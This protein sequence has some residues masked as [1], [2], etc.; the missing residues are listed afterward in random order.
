[1]KKFTSLALAV[2]SLA[3]CNK[4]KEFVPAASQA[5]EF[6]ITATRESG[7]TKT[8]L[9]ADGKSVW[10]SVGDNI[11][12]FYGPGQTPSAFIGQNTAE[13]ASAEFRGTLDRS[14]SLDEYPAEARHMFGIYP[15]GSSDKVDADGTIWLE[16]R[17]SQTAVNGSFET[18][19]FPA[20]AV[21]DNEKFNFLNVA[22][23]IRFSVDAEDVSYVKFS[24]NGNE[25]LAGRVGVKFSDGVPVVGSYDTSFS[26]VCVY[27][28]KEGFVKGESYYAVLLPVTFANGITIT[29]VPNSGDPIEIVSGKAQTLKRSTIADIGTIG[30]PKALEI[31]TVWAKFSTS[32][33]AWNEYY[34]GTAGTDRNIAMDDD[35]VYIAENSVT[36]KLWA[37]SISDHNSVT[38]VNI[39]GVSG[40]THP[41]SCPRVIKN[42]NPAVNGGKDVLACSSLTRGGE[43]PK[44]YLWLDGINNP[45]K[46]V[47]LTTWATDSWYGDTFTVSGTLQDGVLFFDKTDSGGNGIVTFNLQGVPGDKLYLLKRIAFNA[48]FGSHNGICAYY[49]FPEN[50]NCGIFSPGR[51]HE[52]RGQFA[53]FDGDLKSEVNVP[54]TP[55]LTPLEYADGRNGFVLGYN[56]IEWEGKRYVI[57]GKQPDTAN[58]Y[59]YVLEGEAAQDWLE[60]INFAPVKFRRDLAVTSGGRTSGNSGMDVTARVIDGELYFAAQKQNVACGLYKLIYK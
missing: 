60:I 48:T 28:P 40:G 3:A 50:S 33:G 59:V 54:Y 46:A 57:Y 16:L 43:D 25:T 36:P 24:G 52:A 20:V 10:W 2:L 35:Y 38:P 47:T 11:N 37:I 49:P 1:M 12:V 56:F 55:T 13:A 32:E 34:G 15:A 39:E 45:P 41:L 27:A 53:S 26:D 8:A 51:G 14:A 9:Q 42:T 4:E 17:N 22:G 30:A 44:L 19:L 29:L 23:A 5:E 58:G 7:S 18:D 6:T 21:S 31:E